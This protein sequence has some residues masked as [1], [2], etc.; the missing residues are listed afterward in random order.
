MSTFHITVREMPFILHQGASWG[1]LTW[2]EV[3][4]LLLG[5]VHS[6]PCRFLSL[7]EVLNSMRECL[8]NG[9]GFTSQERLF[10][11]DDAVWDR[12][13]AENA[14][15]RFPCWFE[16]PKVVIFSTAQLKMVKDQIRMKTARRVVRSVQARVDE[17]MVGLLPRLGLGVAKELYKRISL[18][19]VA[20]D[21]GE[22]GKRAR[23]SNAR[24]NGIC[25]KLFRVS[26]SS[27]KDCMKLIAEQPWPVTGL[28]WKLPSMIVGGM[29]RSDRD[30]TV[31]VFG[32][33]LFDSV[34]QTLLLV[35]KKLA[36]L[37]PQFLLGS[38]AAF[39]GRSYKTG[40][41]SFNLT[42]ATSENCLAFAKLGP[43]RISDVG[44]KVIFF[45]LEK[46]VVSLGENLA[47]FV[48]SLCSLFFNW[49]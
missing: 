49:F 40:S 4:F 7:D 25:I 38:K 3:F 36:A 2:P 17:A 6:E 45:L 9:I 19:D 13:R 10:F 48:A 14:A 5:K 21:R 43:F 29:I 28:Q 42:F 26:A 31:T 44:G 27:F 46:C 20:E 39:A 30:R 12:R 33:P 8:R 16:K 11:S 37:A 34:E 15:S 35:T 22:P 23:L 24:V 32:V 18:N 47:P 41:I 1:Q